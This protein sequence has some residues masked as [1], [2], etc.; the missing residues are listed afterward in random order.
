MLRKGFAERV[1]NEHRG[2]G[3]ARKF[4]TNKNINKKLY[5]LVSKKYHER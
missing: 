3:V 5:K 4:T 2:V 1:L